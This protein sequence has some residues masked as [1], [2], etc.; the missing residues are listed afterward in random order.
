[1]KSEQHYFD[2]QLVAIMIDA[3]IET[4]LTENHRDFADITEI[5]AIN[6]FA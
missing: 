1:M 4:I 2:A 5:R 3:G 6:P